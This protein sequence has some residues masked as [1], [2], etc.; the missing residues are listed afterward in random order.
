MAKIHP[1]KVGTILALIV[2]RYN[3]RIEVGKRILFRYDGELHNW[4]E[5][6]I[7][8]VHDNGWFAISNW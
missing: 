3:Y 7:E 8:R 6:K 4:R 2:L 1:G 5:G